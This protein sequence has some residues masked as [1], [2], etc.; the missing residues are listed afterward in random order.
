MCDVGGTGVLCFCFGQL[1]SQVTEVF[2]GIKDWWLF[3]ALMFFLSLSL[4]LDGHD[5]FPQSSIHYLVEWMIMDVN[6]QVWH[7]IPIQPGF[8]TMFS[9]MQIYHPAVGRNELPHSNKHTC[10]RL[11]WTMNKRQ[12]QMFIDFLFKLRRTCKETSCIF[13]RGGNH[14]PNVQRQCCKTH[15]WR[16]LMTCPGSLWGC[17]M[18]ICMCYL[19]PQGVM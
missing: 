4:C 9:G 17:W 19:R 5:F 16:P 13:T 2:H 7:G 8:H 3:L 11:F 15:S 14:C 6:G 12:I 18:R 1:L 10:P